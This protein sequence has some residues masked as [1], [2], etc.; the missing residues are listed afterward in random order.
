MYFQKFILVSSLL[1]IVTISG[2]VRKKDNPFCLSCEK[3]KLYYSQ[4]CEGYP[5]FIKE[6][7]DSLFLLGNVSDEFK[8]D[9]ISVCISLKPHSGVT[10][11]GCPVYNKIKCLR[12]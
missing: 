5:L 1:I 3:G 10:Y 12:R 8:K 7:G 2:C 6:N 11:G 4:N 9:G